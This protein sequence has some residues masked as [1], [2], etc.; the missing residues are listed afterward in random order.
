MKIDESKKPV[1]ILVCV[2]AII[3]SF[4]S[5]V[6]TQCKGT[7]KYVK[8]VDVCVGE[9]MASQVAKILNNNGDVVVLS[10]AGNTKFKSVVAEAQM[11]G[12]RKGLKQFSGVNVV[13]VV[14]PEQQQMMEFFEG[15]SEK[16][17]LKVVQDY[18]NAKAIVSFMGL[19]VF[20]KEGKPID[21][22]K[23]PKVVALN[24]SAMGQWRDL[25]SN[26]VVSAVILPRYDVRW[27][28]LTKKGECTKLFE[29]R[30]LIVTK[31]NFKQMEEQLKKFYP[32]PPGAPA[33]P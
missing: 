23:L 26:G 6:R 12:F 28:Q 27:D 30:Y 16:F 32:M 15:V 11:E 2:I 8:T 18:P 21:I 24:L 10:M 33:G 3:V 29:E 1:V 22:T 17:F 13:G 31:D 9:Q 4:I 5:I 19:P 20:A 25:V 7:P 14:G